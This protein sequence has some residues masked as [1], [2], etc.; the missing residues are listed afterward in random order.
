[1]IVLVNQ[2]NLFENA[3]QCEKCTSKQKNVRSAQQWYTWWSSCLIRFPIFFVIRCLSSKVVLFQGLIF[4]T[5]S[6]RCLFLFL[7]SMP[8]GGDSLNVYVC[9]QINQTTLIK[10]IPTM[11]QRQ[12][13]QRMLSTDYISPKIVDVAL[14]YFSLGVVDKW[15][16]NLGGRVSMILR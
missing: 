7:F 15:P 2:R 12:S 13:Y 8:R 16:H 10:P 11:T 14:S 4:K 5:S 9:S 3:L 6:L 1:M